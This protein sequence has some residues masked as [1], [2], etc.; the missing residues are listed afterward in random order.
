MDKRL[1]KLP[2]EFLEKVKRVYP[3]EHEQVFRT[4]LEERPSTFRVNY[5]KTDLRTLRDG[6]RDQNILYR[7]APNVPGAFI[8][9]KTT[10]RQLQET[11]EYKNGHIYVQNL[12]SMI[13]V[14]ELLSG[15]LDFTKTFPLE[16]N[17]CRG[18]KILDLCSAPGGKTMHIASLTGG[19]AE[20]VAVEKDKPR[21]FK[22]RANLEM[23]GAISKVQTILDNGAAT[24]KDFE[25]QFD[26][27]LVDAPCSCE[28]GFDVNTPRSYSYWSRHK[29]QECRDKQKRLIFSG[30]R[31]L[32]PGGTLVYST[33]TISPEEN[34]FVIDWALKRFPE[35]RMETL[36]WQHQGFRKGITD[37]G[38]KPFNPDVAKARRV[39]PDALYESFFVAKIKKAA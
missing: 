16:P 4:F 15:Y 17:P 12:S 13:P 14:F 36:R 29:V 11:P 7:D 3:Q 33:C 6:L 20:I 9:T 8:L 19:R 24:F 26:L 1:E 27:V 37:W 31:C 34:E 25:E 22:L 35:C 10:L 30:I 23:Q 38:E 18:I 39:F 21:F 32:K 28:S 5:L 2:A